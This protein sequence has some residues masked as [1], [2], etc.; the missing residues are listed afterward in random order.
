MLLGNLGRSGA[1]VFGDLLALRRLRGWL[2]A[3]LQPQVGNLVLL[4]V[5]YAEALHLLVARVKAPKTSFKALCSSKKRGMVLVRRRSS[6]KLRSIRFV[7]RT[8]LR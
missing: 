7:V 8:N 1:L 2:D 5:G 4:K 3:Q 6:S